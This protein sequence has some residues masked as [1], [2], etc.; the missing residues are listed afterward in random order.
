MDRRTFGGDIEFLEHQYTSFT[1]SNNDERKRKSYEI[2]W[3]GEMYLENLEILTTLQQLCKPQFRSPP[4]QSLHRLQNLDR[5]T[6]SIALNNTQEHSSQTN[7][8][9]EEI[10]MATDFFRAAIHLEIRRVVVIG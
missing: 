1:Q 4:I 10:D 3:E 9:F 5:R 6:H 8:T 2:S 7:A